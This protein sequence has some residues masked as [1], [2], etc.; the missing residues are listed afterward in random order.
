MECAQFDLNNNGRQRRQRQLEDE[1]EYYV[2]PYCADQG[3]E[4]HLGLFADDTCTTFVTN[5]ESTFYSVMGY[6]LPFSDASLVSNRCMSCNDGE[7]DVNEV[8]EN[9]YAVSGKCETKMN[10]AYPNESACTYIEGIK[11]IR[12]DGVIRTSKTK[13]SKAAAVCIG[14]FLTLAVLLAAYVMYLRTKLGRAKINLSAAAG[15][16]LA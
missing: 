2:G 13:K 7:G 11:I 5:G 1:M 16:T 14:L 3:G 15:A 10:F 4:I 8:C 9:I 12:A 6:E